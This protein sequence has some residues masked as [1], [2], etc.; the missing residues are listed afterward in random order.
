MT[1]SMSGL[2]FGIGTNDPVTIIAA[3]AF[4]IAIAAAAC[5]IPA[6]RACR[7]DPAQA[8]RTE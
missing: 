3:G 2:V 1:R 8:L 6:W 4:L 7:I 5:F